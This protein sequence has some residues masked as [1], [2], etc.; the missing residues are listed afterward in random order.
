M[1]ATVTDPAELHE[2]RL[3]RIVAHIPTCPW[4]DSKIIA[5]PRG[6]LRCDWCNRE[7]DGKRGRDGVRVWRRVR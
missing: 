6:G 4:C 5:L 2:R 1:S 3:E 7:S